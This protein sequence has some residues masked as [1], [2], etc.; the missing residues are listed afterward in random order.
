MNLLNRVPPNAVEMEKVVLGAIMI[1]RDALPIASELLR[2]EMFYHIHH[3]IVYSAILELGN[4]G[5]NIDLTTVTDQLK[6]DKKL[7]EIG[8]QAGVAMLTNNV[9]SS[10]HTLNHC[11]KIVEKYLLREQIRI[12]GELL[13]K[14]YDENS[15]PFENIE[16]AEGDLHTLTMNIQQKEVQTIDTVVV[17]V[18]QDIEQLRHREHYLTGVGSGYR[19]LDIPT[20]GW[21]PSDLIILAA[22]PSVGKTAFALSLAS[23]AA[24]S[25]EPVAFFS[26]EMSAKQ[27]VKRV[28][29]AESEMYLKTIRDARMDDGQMRHLYKNGVQK[30]AGMPFYIDDTASLTVGQFKA[31]CR[32]LVRKHKVKLIILDYLQLIKSTLGKNTNRQQ[33]IGDISR[34]LK[35]TA[36]ELDVP[37]IALSQLSREIEKRST[38]VPQLSD[39]RE[40]GDIE[41]DADVVMFLYGHSEKECKDDAEKASEIMLKVAKHRNGELETFVFDFDKPLQKFHDKGIHAPALLSIGGRKTFD[42]EITF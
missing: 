2:P 11:R 36:K 39:L 25:G 37:I 15:D 42:E 21:Q 3:Q 23:N 7:E 6:A 28:L 5:W 18:M 20:C 9:V 8:G 35:I 38:Q 33:Q 17:Q 27:L 29:A 13:T 32:R 22:R 24:R 14:G 40:A 19:S 31:K 4:K 34:E 41:Q 16:R 30:V 26:L 10:A 12:A 1:D